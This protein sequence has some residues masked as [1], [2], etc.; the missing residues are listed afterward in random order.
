MNAEQAKIIGRTVTEATLDFLASKHETTARVI[1]DLIAAGHA[2]M[3]AQF[4]ALMATGMHEA[5]THFY[6]TAQQ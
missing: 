2:N 3:T 5:I 1:A 4:H 6:A